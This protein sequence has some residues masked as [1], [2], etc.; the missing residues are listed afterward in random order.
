MFE[1]RGK[2]VHEIYEKRDYRR[3]KNELR[4]ESCRKHRRQCFGEKIHLCSDQQARSETKQK[5]TAQYGRGSE[6]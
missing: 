4:L 6:T 1:A 5:A 3:V 2:H